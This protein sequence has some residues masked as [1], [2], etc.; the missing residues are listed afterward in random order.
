MKDNLRRG[1]LK[2]FTVVCLL[3]ILLVLLCLGYNYL[4]GG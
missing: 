2:V 3:W 4:G 1:G